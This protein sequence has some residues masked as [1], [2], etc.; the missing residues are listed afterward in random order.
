MKKILI[1]DANNL[2]YRFFFAMDSLATH[3]G[4]PTTVIYNV[5]KF[6]SL[7]AYN[8]ESDDTIIV[9]DGGK[10]NRQ[11]LNPDYKA[12][13]P[14]RPDTLHQEMS[15]AYKYFKRLG[16][17][18]ILING[19]EADDIIGVLVKKYCKKKKVYILSNDSDFYQL[20]QYHN[21]RMY[22]SNHD[23]LN[24]KMVCKKLGLK[25][26][27]DYVTYKAL[28]GDGSDNVKGVS[29]IG[30]KKAQALL[31][32]YH[33]TALLCALDASPSTPKAIIKAKGVVD[34]QIELL[35]QNIEIL[36]IKS[37]D[38]YLQKKIK[39]YLARYYKDIVTEREIESIFEELEFKT[40][41]DAGI[42]KFVFEM[43]INK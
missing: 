24:K 16:I 42:T 19:Y 10:S 26:I 21:V 9:W 15:L 40:F 20:L 14:N 25:S 30:P 27:K 33:R 37:S 28:V 39:K 6:I 35:E 23:V 29:G 11:S 1:A 36:T 5:L 31:E 12:H 17:K 22:K 7:T 38:E 4:I 41:L 43:G 13:R 18:Q 8:L 3:D 32:H 2:A 34:A